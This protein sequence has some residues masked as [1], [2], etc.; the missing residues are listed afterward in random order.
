MS[1]LS[2]LTENTKWAGVKSKLCENLSPKKARVVNVLLENTR[3]QMIFEANNAATTSSNIASINK[4]ILPLIRRVVPSVIANEIM[5][6]VPM[7]GP[8]GQIN[9]LRVQY[10]E[11][12]P[13]DAS[14]VIA[15]QEVFS[16]D[17]L[18][19]YYSGNEKVA[20]PDAAETA[21]LEFKLGRKIKVQLVKETVT[22]KSHRLSAEWTIE[23]QQ[24]AQAQYGLNIET[25]IFAAVAQ[26]MTVEI[27]QIMLGKMRRL[28]G[29]PTATYDQN[30]L[31]GE[32]IS[33][34]DQHA[35]FAVLVGQQANNIARKTRR[36][37]GN[38]LVLPVDA[39]SV[40]QSA[41]YSG[42]VQ[43]TKGNF[44]QPTNTRMVGTLNNTINVYVDNYATNA[45]GAL[46]VY[47][48]PTEV[49]ACAFYCPFIPLTSIGTVINPD[50]AAL[51]TSFLTRYGY[52]ELSNST[53]SLGNAKDYTAKIALSNLHFS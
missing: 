4:V 6:V 2:I 35:A 13:A 39:L 1:N 29:S 9:T 10:G 5:G 48:G 28:A 27:D 3:K 47:K 8:V 18:A 53:S 45:D 14:G 51:V 37:P 7:T 34:V 19:R 30:S 23:A 24:D 15:G 31:S 33:V 50:T 11:T 36:G 49:D 40:L 41:K 32:A 17:M 42:F 21:D 52:C 46:L 22:A 12:V 43:S 26:E 25:E 20:D 44:D 38:K 16:P